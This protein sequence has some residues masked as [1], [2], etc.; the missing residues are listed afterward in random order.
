MPFTPPN[1]AVL[2]RPPPYALVL[3][4]VAAA[5]LWAQWP[6]LAVL[7]RRWATD[8]QYSHGYLVVLFAGYLAWTRRVH[9]LSPA[10]T[11][12][13]WGWALLGLGQF[14]SL[15]GT[16]VSFDWLRAAALLPTLAGLAVLWGGRPAL[17]GAWPALAFLLFMIPLPYRV[18]VALAHPLQR[19]ATAASTYTLQTL[20]YDAVAFGNVIDLDPARI[21]VEQACSGLSMLLVFI[22][23]ATAAALVLR[24]PPADRILIVAS[25]VPIALVANV[26]RIV[27]TGILYQ[28]VGRKWADL[29]FHDLAGWLMMPLAL[30][31]MWLELRLVSWVLVPPPVERPIFA[32]SVPRQD[33]VRTKKTTDAPRGPS[34]PGRVPVSE[35]DDAAAVRA[36][37]NGVVKG[38]AT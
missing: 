21:G 25:A 33:H 37:D 6:T 31:L 38:Q 28:T 15:A 16:Y 22:A 36:N 8:P 12:S 2:R 29:V 27:A 10:A 13:W 18:E 26:V 3:A 17:R 7:T 19:L 11:P 5:L 20:G 35:P 30:G 34:P 23:L 32:V 24:R 4:A 1:L 14:L 9:F